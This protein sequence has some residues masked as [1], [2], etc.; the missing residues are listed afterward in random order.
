MHSAYIISY[1][2]AYTIPLAS[3]IAVNDAQVTNV[4]TCIYFF[5]YLYPVF[6]IFI[7]NLRQLTYP[8]YLPSLQQPCDVGWAERE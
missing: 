7:D 5:F 4:N 1:I 3:K 6:V 8:T 2:Y